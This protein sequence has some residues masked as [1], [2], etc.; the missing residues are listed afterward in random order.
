MAT[1]IAPTPVV[2]EPGAVI[3]RRGIV[4]W[5]VSVDHKRIAVVMA[6]TALV[7]FVCFGALALIMRTQLAQPNQHLIGFQLYDEF[8][9]LHGSGMIVLVITPLA[10]ALCLYL[11]PLQVGAPG[12]AAPRTCLFS[13]WLYV[14]AAFLFL[15]ASVTDDG[16]TSG[17]YSYVPLADSRYT[18][19][20][21]QDIWIMAMAMGVLAMLLPS[22]AILW[23]AL[24]M[25]APGMSL[26]RM[27]VF[28]WSAVVTCMMSV[29]AF[30]A[31]LAAEGLITAGRVDPTLFNHDYWDVAY[32][33]IFW[34]YGHPVVYVMFFPF[35]GCVAQVLAT[36]SGRPYEGYQFTVFALLAFAAGSMAVWGHHMYTTG[37]ST[38][39]FFTISSTY[40]AVP[41][42]VEYFGFLGTI[43]GGKLR[44]NTPMLF[45]LAFIPQFAI[46]GLTGI[47]LA[48]PVLDYD[49]HGTYFVVAHFHYTLMAG[50]VFGGFA[51][52]YYWFPKAT[53]IMLDDRIG[54]VHFWL[55]TVGVNTTFL[56]MFFSGIDGMPRRVATYQASLG[57]GDFN[58][59]STIG[60]Y[61]IALSVLVFIHNV[62]VSSRR[63]RVT[64]PDPWGDG[65]TLEWATSTP[66]PT[67]NYDAAH[68]IPRIKSHAPLWTLRHEGEEGATVLAPGAPA[69]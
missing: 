40:L 2:V 34:F 69:P 39:D 45:A 18:P 20:A 52:L 43:I 60:A 15:I 5:F 3:G 66:P 51:G 7:L 65:Q 6:G 4:G 29:A 13:Y 61:I 64:D 12:V 11:V 35:V 46:G 58:L 67:F 62:F 54:K 10:I 17:W 33:W 23:T 49:F 42:G 28:T 55:M 9:T 57:V 8:F 68:P 37:Q 21:G 32:Q 56:P 30:P 31:L 22:A 27:S 19:G 53:G 25:R 26:M 38:N 14:F 1:T 24:R 59:V 63:P 48:A 44:F 41:A 47:M 36:F 16:P 50:S